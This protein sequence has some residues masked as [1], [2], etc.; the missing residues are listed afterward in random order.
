[1]SISKTSYTLKYVNINPKV[2]FNSVCHIVIDN[3]YL[4]TVFSHS[5]LLNKAS[6]LH[7]A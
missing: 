1:M 2:I 7:Y 4:N 6:K 3:Y 5:S